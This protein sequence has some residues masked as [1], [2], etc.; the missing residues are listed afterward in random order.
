MSPTSRDNF[1]NM[2]YVD[3]TLAA[4]RRT[5]RSGSMWECRS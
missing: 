3:D 1:Y 2:T 5:V 4:G